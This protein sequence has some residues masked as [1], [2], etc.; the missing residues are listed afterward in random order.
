CRGTRSSYEGT[1]PHRPLCSYATDAKSAI[2]QAVL[3]LSK[4]NEEAHN[5][6]PEMYSHAVREEEKGE[7]ERE[8]EGQGGK[9]Q[10]S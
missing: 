6:D 4:V 5:A 7:E 9:W 1:C 8:R 2:G 10:R 3:H